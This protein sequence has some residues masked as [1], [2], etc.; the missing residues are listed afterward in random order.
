MVG[1]SLR[2]DYILEWKMDFKDIKAEMYTRFRQHL[3]TVHDEKEPLILSDEHCLEYWGKQGPLRSSDVV[4]WL[5]ANVIKPLSQHEGKEP[6]WMSE[7]EGVERAASSSNR[8]E[9][10]RRKRS[11]G[12]RRHVSGRDDIDDPVDVIGS[13]AEI[14]EARSAAKLVQDADR[15][16]AGTLANVPRRLFNAITS[17]SSKRPH[18]PEILRKHSTLL[19]ESGGSCS[20]G[21]SNIVMQA[22]QASEMSGGRPMTITEIHIGAPPSMRV[23]ESPYEHAEEIRR[24]LSFISEPHLLVSVLKMVNGRMAE[25]RANQ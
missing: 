17:T 16:V 13:P 19:Q 2:P 11:S 8:N 22:A 23:A 10:K 9:M 4:A 1:R 18:S 3:M 25:I 15:V 5:A 6:E 14:R 12:S 20:T 21:R 24:H 7:H